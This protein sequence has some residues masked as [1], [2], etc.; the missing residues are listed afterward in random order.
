MKY[1][2]IIRFT[3]FVGI[4]AMIS[5]CE[6]SED[7]VSQSDPSTEFVDDV[8][9]KSAHNPNGFIHGIVVD[10]DGIDYYFDGAPDGPNGAIDVPGHSWVQSG[11]NR[12]VGKHYNTGPAGAPQWWSSDAPNGELLYIVHAIIDEWSMMKAKHYHARG[13]VHYHEF[14]EVSDGTTL[15]PA[16]VVWLK[17]TAVTSFT[18]DRGPKGQGLDF[19]APYTHQVTPG[20]DMEFPNNGMMT[21]NP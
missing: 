15:H 12:L 11:P 10:I 8:F 1:L 21:Y 2:S 20:V 9:L 18:L 6:K 17:H 5:A 13:F 3:A 19:P 16:K 7:L 4:I 14:V